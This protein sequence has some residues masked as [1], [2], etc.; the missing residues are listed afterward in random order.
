MKTD[1]CINGRGARSLGSYFD[2]ADRYTSCAGQLEEVARRINDTFTLLT[3]KIG[4]VNSVIYS[5]S[6]YRGQTK[7]IAAKA[8]T[9]QA[10]A[11]TLIRKIN[12][13]TASVADEKEYYDDFTGPAERFYRAAEN[14]KKSAAMLSL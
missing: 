5:N 7:G 14:L 3:E 13:H 11:D 12:G 8:E 1:Y 6:A 2:P 4:F 9:L 10:S